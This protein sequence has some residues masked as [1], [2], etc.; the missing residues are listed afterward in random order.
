PTMSHYLKL[1]CD[2][3]FEEKNFRNEIIWQRADAHND[4]RKF[5]SIH[6][7]ILFYTKNKIYNWNAIY[8]EYSQEYLTQK[9]NATPQGRLYKCDDMTDPRKS[10]KEFDFMGSVA[11]W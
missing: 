1:V 7:T 5:G 9:W 11:R 2:M 10:M 6:D 4:P 8:S 3:I